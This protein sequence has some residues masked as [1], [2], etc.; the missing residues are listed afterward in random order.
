MVS[1]EY[2]PVMY[3]GLGRHVHALAS[4]LTV[5]GHDVTVLTQAATGTPAEQPGSSSE[6]QVVRALLPSDFP[7]VYADTAGFVAGLQPRLTEAA[8]PLLATW[9]PDVVHG[10]DWVVAQAA[11]ILSEQQHCPLVTTI[12]ATEAGLYQGNVVSPFS[13]WRHGVERDVVAQAAATIVCSAAMRA[14]VVDRLGADDARV[15]VVP[16]G[17]DEA[18]WV[19]SAPQRLAARAR[20]GLTDEPLLVLVGRLEHEKGAQ[21][22]IDAVALLSRRWPTLHLALVGDG[23]RAAD[24]RAQADRLGV[25]ERVHAVGRL[26][27]DQVAAMVAAADVALVPSRYEPFGLVALEAMAAGTPVVVC[28]TGGLVDVVVDGVSGLVVAPADPDS[29]AQAVDGLLDDPGRRETLAQAASARVAARFGWAA[30][31]TATA[32]VYA[33]VLV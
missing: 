11:T 8:G 26:V 14:E 25:T 17:V 29:L 10:H 18:R 30:V 9:Q 23:A 4:A 13:R 12:H 16:N 2:P 28:A 27:G 32:D 1:W 6:P 33:E 15:S 19:T 31:A 22:A 20:L 24:L 21:D 5:A 7:D 3:G